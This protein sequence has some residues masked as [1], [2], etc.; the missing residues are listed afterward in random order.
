MVTRQNL[1]FD[2]LCFDVSR[3]YHIGKKGTNVD[4]V[5]FDSHFK[6]RMVTNYTKYEPIGLNQ[7]NSNSCSD[8]IADLVTRA[9]RL[10]Q[11]ALV[12]MIVSLSKVPNYLF[13]FTI[14]LVSGTGGKLMLWLN[15]L[16][17]GRGD[18]IKAF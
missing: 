10:N 17:Y 9:K 11:K 16:R 18:C 3:T 1:Y 15:S 4:K 8:Y 13:C 6:D 2:C 12:Q 14:I 5:F 7:H